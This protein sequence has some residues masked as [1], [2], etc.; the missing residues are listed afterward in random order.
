MSAAEVRV[1]LTPELRDWVEEAI[2]TGDYAS[3]S[4]VILDALQYWLQPREQ[5]GE[6]VL[7]LRR[8]WDEG[9]ASGPAQHSDMGGVKAEARQRSARQ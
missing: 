6:A 3:A 8:L 7:Q 1:E 2:A 4:D 5:S 9:I